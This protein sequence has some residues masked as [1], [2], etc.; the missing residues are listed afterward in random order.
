MGIE[1]QEQPKSAKIPANKTSQIDLLY[2]D[3]KIQMEELR[4]LRPYKAAVNEIFKLVSL[5]GYS[6]ELQEVC[7]ILES[8]IKN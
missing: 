3:I 6:E 4:E 5:N 2:R 1:L 8:H 7:R